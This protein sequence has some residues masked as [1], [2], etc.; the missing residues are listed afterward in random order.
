VA[1]A[2]KD[3]NIVPDVIEHQVVGPWYRPK[4]ETIQRGWTIDRDCREIGGQRSLGWDT[5][6][7]V[8]LGRIDRRTILG[9]DGCIYVSYWCNVEPWN[10]PNLTYMGVLPDDSSRLTRVGIEPQYYQ[11]IEKGLVRF[12][13]DNGLDSS[14][15]S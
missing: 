2:A 10:R 5:T 13:I 9:L 14:A 1:Q 8:S 7:Y 11:E 4:R 12:I 6:E 3:K 15:S